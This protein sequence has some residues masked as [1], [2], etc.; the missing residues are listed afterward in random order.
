MD[1]ANDIKIKRYIK[2]LPEAISVPTTWGEAERCLLTG[3]S[4]DAVTPPFDFTCGGILTRGAQAVSSKL[5][6]LTNEHAR[7]ISSISAFPWAEQF[8]SAVTLE[9]YIHLDSLYRSRVLS[10]PHSPALVPVLD[11]ANHTTPANAFYV[12]ENDALV[13]RAKGPLREG[14]EVTIDYS[15]G[16]KSA[17]EMLFSYGFIEEGREVV[18]GMVVG[19]GSVVGD[20]PLGGAKRRVWG[21]EPVLRLREEEGEVGWECEFIWYVGTFFCAVG[22]RLIGNRLAVVNAEDGLDFKV[23]QKED[24]GRELVMFWRDREVEARGVPELVRE[25]EMAKVYRLRAVV[26]L[27][28][29]VQEMLG[30][31]EGSEEACV[32]VHEMGLVGE[33]A[34]IGAMALR[35]LEGGLMRKALQDME[36]EKDELLQED[37]VVEYLKKMQ[38]EGEEEQDEVMGEVDLS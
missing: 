5:T 26:V 33:Q 14:E 8:T 12:L 29:A 10:L 35:K 20:D 7:F 23:L 32:Q 31:L 6:S 24:G 21:K 2:F 27:M 36:K 18:G 25:S 13:L 28:S 11:F 34:W 16:E 4:L 3:T 17:A 1:G 37:V 22:G 9:V 30:E 19:V 38:E 15:A